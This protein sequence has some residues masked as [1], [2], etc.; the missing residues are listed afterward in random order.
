LEE[1]YKNLEGTIDGD[2]ES[3]HDMRVASRRLRAAMSVFESAFP[4][5]QFI[6]LEKEA[7]RVTDALGDVRDS[8][9]QIEYITSRRESASPAEQVGLDAL[10]AHL[11]FERERHRKLL[12]KE[13]ERLGKSTF[14]SDFELMLGVDKAEVDG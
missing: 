1:L 4:T 5:K 3:L 14:R 2:V 13:L 8:D 11:T 9:V 10:I 12:I 7:S 6:P